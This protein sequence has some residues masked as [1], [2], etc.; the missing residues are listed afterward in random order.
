MTAKD[1]HTTAMQKALPPFAWSEFKVKHPTSVGAAGLT[2]P[3][4]WSQALSR[5]LAAV[6]SKVNNA[7]VPTPDTRGLSDT[8]D[9]FPARGN[10]NDYAV[11]K[12]DELLKAGLPASC[13]LLAEVVIPDGEH[14]MVLIVRTSQDDIVL[15]NL[16]VALLSKQD[17]PYRMVRM[18][19]AE[20]PN[21]WVA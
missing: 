7:I 10:C 3:L 19:A 11:S 4:P 9:L 12:R 1:D 18:Q 6:N 14:H 2:D 21:K 8:W 15:D 20:D 5:Q 16:T 17:M 13:L